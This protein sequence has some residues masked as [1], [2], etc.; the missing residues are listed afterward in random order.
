LSARSELKTELAESWIET[1]LPIN[2]VGLLHLCLTDLSRF[3]C[4][5][6]EMPI[7]QEG[8]LRAAGAYDRADGD[9]GDH[10]VS[11]GASG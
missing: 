10:A 9:A 1:K 6:A 5:C 11:L 8:P 2:E 3:T 4:G 7:M